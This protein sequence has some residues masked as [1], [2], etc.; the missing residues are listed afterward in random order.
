M[1]SESNS[2][3][4]SVP[5]SLRV[6]AIAATFAFGGTVSFHAAA[7]ESFPEYLAEKYEE[8]PCV[9]GCTLCH[10]T[11][12]GGLNTMRPGSFGASL[13]LTGIALGSPPE[14]GAPTSLDPVLAAMEAMGT[15]I[16]MDD[17][18]DIDELKAGTD[19]GGGVEPLCDVPQYGCGASVAPTA[20]TRLGA[21][22]L[23][24]SVMLVLFFRRRR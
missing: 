17:A 4:R 22:G 10:I 24:F 16:D 18:P 5:I 12:L 8:M 14:A 6:L 11:N 7:S 19:P 20:P 3:V 13:Y 1:L 15:N 2:R 21:L 9:P 23:A